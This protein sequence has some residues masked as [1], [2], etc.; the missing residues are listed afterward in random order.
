MKN[1]LIFGLGVV[2]GAIASATYVKDRY[3]KECD[4]EIAS[5]K[6]YYKEKFAN[7]ESDANTV[8]EPVETTTN[9]ICDNSNK[10]ESD[11]AVVHVDKV[12]YNN[13]V[14][15][16]GYS[17]NE[18]EVEEVAKKEPYIITPEEFD[19]IG[20]DTVSLTYYSDKILTNEKD[21]PIDDIDDLI[22]EDSLEHFGQYEDDSVF[23]RN[24]KLKTD[25]EILL[26]ER[27]YYE[28]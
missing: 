6:K 5:V 15:D 4:E 28:N 2:L 21:E 3:R 14:N 25:F 24:D 7:M 13:I 9:D 18:K 27:R 1:V 17:N 10:F 11:N 23:V 20:Y 26:D 12:S 8:E 19:S 16:L 22:G